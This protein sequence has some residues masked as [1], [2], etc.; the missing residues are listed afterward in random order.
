MLPS[1]SVAK[2]LIYNARIRERVDLTDAL[3][4]FHIV[5]DEPITADGPWFVPGQ[6]VVLG[7]NNEAEPDKGSV[8]RAMSIGSAPEEKDRVE[9]YIRYVSKPESD[10]PLTHLLWKTRAGDPLY[11]RMKPTGK[12]TVNDT[13]GAGDTRL[14]VFVAAGTGL[15]PFVSIV[16]SHHLR[17]PAAALDQYCILHGASYPDDLGYR[18][19]LNRYADSNRLHYYSTVSRPKE[20]PGWTGDA[21]RVEDYFKVERLEE[22]EDRL[23]LGRGGFNPD[24][25][26]VLVC[27]LQGTITESITRLATRGFVPDHRK[28]RRALEVADDTPSSLFFEQY[29]NTP[30]IDTDNPDVVGPLRDQI[31]SARASLSGR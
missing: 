8:R 19:E 28:I 24:N 4:I 21:G 3:T 31:R 26:V 12:F 27:G 15:A 14:K 2:P 16:R 18:D 9:F 5:P 6:Y 20:A 23:G 13:C 7:M 29:D 30:V 10:N 25:V 17:E 1:P 11:M 22:L